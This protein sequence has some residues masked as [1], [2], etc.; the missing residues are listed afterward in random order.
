MHVVVKRQGKWKCLE[1]SASKQVSYFSPPVCWFVP[2]STLY[3][4]YS[5]MCLLTR[6]SALPYRMHMEED[7]I[8]PVISHHPEICHVLFA[9]QPITGQNRCSVTAWAQWKSPVRGCAGACL[10]LNL[11][12]NVTSLWVS[13]YC[14][15]RECQRPRERKLIQS[16][17][18]FVFSG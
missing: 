18:R 17:S 12:L 4:M 3:L 6:P 7:K 1:T 2:E 8:W 10:C 9:S 15:E 5:L 11:T 13:G 14:N 16:A